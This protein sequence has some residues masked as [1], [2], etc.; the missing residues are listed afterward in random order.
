MSVT[1]TYRSGKA[2][3]SEPLAS[4]DGLRCCHPVNDEMIAAFSCPSGYRTHAR[5][6]RCE[7]ADGL[8]AA[9]PVVSVRLS[10]FWW[11]QPTTTELTRKV[12]PGSLLDGAC[13]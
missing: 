6:S 4:G 1:A 10:A 7:G 3:R 13:A 2:A 5:P 12:L 9:R 8:S 11:C